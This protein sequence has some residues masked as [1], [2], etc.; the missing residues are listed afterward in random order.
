MADK[1]DKRYNIPPAY[2]DRADEFWWSV[3]NMQTK[4][5]RWQ[6]ATGGHTATPSRYLASAG[7]DTDWGREVYG[8]GPW[9]TQSVADGYIAD[10]KAAVEAW[11]IN[12][13]FD[14]GSSALYRTYDYPPLSRWFLI[15]APLPFGCTPFV[16]TMDIA[17]D[18]EPGV[19]DLVG[20]IRWTQARVSW[21]VG[22]T[23]A[24]I[25]YRYYYILVLRDALQIQTGGKGGL[26]DG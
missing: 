23:I 14:P 9:M 13:G 20:R 19:D 22:K 10:M 1:K 8:F 7:L 15:Q 17:T 6:G 3:A 4:W 26:I 12:Q 11:E 5:P 24:G 21:A 18:P 25:M 2:R 16:F